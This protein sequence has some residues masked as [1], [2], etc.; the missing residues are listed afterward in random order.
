MAQMAAQT[1]YPVPRLPRL[2]G[3]PAAAAAVTRQAWACRPTSR[4]AR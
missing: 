3:D 4:S 1:E 2:A